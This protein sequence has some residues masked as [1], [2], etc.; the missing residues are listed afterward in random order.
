MS[1]GVF[2][3]GLSWAA[4]LLAVLSLLVV[5][6]S[7]AWGVQYA[8]S[9]GQ[10]DGGSTIDEAGAGVLTYVEVGDADGEDDDPPPKSE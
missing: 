10:D 7:D 9:V 5:G 6:K 2:R 3:S 1:Q 8:A 4:R